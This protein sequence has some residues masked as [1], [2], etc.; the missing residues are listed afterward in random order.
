MKTDTCYCRNV[1]CQFYGFTGQ[2][3]RLIFH[4]GPDGTPRFRCTQCDHL[5][6]ARAG[7]AYAGF[8]TNECIYQSGARHLAGGWADEK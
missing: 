8:R 7:T 3:A 1:H 4:D 5:V 6:S 2:R